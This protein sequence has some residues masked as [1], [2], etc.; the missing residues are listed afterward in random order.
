MPPEDRKKNLTMRT[1]TLV[2]CSMCLI[3]SC[4]F[5]AYLVARFEYKKEFTGGGLRS[6]AIPNSERAVTGPAIDVLT[7]W[8][9]VETGYERPNTTKAA[10]DKTH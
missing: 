4:V 9:K 6:G 7:S 2:I 8:N 3:G 10:D 1:A 5:S